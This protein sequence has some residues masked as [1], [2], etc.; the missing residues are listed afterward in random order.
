MGGQDSSEL[1]RREEIA[2]ETKERKRQLKE[3][4]KELDQRCA[5]PPWKAF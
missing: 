3:R 2:I 4:Q 1:L 5:A